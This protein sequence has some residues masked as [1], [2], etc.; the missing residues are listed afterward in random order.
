MAAALRRRRQRQVRSR[1]ARHVHEEVEA[2]QQRAG[3]AAAIVR[4]AARRTVA[5]AVRLVNM[6]AAAGIHRGHELEAGRIDNMPVGACDRHPADLQRLPERL[7]RRADE[8]GQ[9]VQ[10]QH[11]AMRQ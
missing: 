7:Q 6:A 9:L 10:E 11:A 5:G 2:V 4:R 1:D 3:K 8:F